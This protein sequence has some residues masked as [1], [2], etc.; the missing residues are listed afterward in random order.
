M[1]LCGQAGSADEAFDLVQEAQPD[2]AVIDI[3]LQDAHGLD[4][5]Q[6]LRAQYPDLQVVI[7]SM[8]D[9]SVYAER[10]LRAGASGYVMK[11]ESTQNVAEAI[12]TVA[13][14]DVYLS[15]RMA[16]RI[17]SKVAM[18][19]STGP[20]FAIDELTDREMAVFQM[21]GQGHGVQE[22]ADRLNLSRKTVETYRRRAKEKLGFESVSELLQYAIQWTYGQVNP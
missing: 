20:G 1:E 5:V 6:N 3:S 18:G 17:L 4:L 21:L 9:E 16:S 14:G 2:V 11:S 8:Y 7:F 15:R 12:R 13:Q 10:A 19:R 22:I